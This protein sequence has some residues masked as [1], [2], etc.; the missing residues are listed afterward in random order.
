[1]AL[2]DTTSRPDPSL[3]PDVRRFLTETIR[4]ATIA[5]ISPDG[6]PHQAVV[7]FLL[8]GDTIVVNSA[9]GRRW[10]TNLRREP[11]LSL[12]VEDG[13]D[14]VRVSGRVEIVDD[15]E[16]AQADIAAMSRRYHADDPQAAE[17]EIREFRSQRRVSFLLRAQSIHAEFGA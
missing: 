13:Y 16:K 2:P 1:M 6:T 15:Q 7:W 17:D 14:W 5:T 4:F 8:D 9:E 3:P 10:P 12:V 11:R